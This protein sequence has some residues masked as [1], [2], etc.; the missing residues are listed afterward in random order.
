MMQF[1]RKWRPFRCIAG[2]LLYV[3]VSV[4]MFATDEDL[5]SRVLV[6]SNASFPESKHVAEYYM[7]KRGIPRENRCEI[8]TGP[9]KL[10]TQLLFWDKYDSTIA[11]P[12]KT[13]LNRVG[14]DH[15]LYIVLSFGVP[16]ALPKAPPNYGRALDSY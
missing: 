5:A 3:A 14:K 9:Q 10:D 11:E 2:L 16:Y 6:V 8:R 4:P 13:C 15:I 7:K 12:I 1:P